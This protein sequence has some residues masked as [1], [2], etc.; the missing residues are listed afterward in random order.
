MPPYA[1]RDAQTAKIFANMQQLGF[2]EE[3]ITVYALG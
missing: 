2:T 3:E 1:Q